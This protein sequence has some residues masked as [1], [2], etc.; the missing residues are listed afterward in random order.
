MIIWGSGSAGGELAETQTQ[1]CT[2]CE[3]ERPFKLFLEYHYA[4]IYFFRWVTDKK[5]H[6]ACDICRRGW[7]LLAKEVEGKIGGN[8]IPFMTRF[9]WTIPLG[10]I[11]A[12]MLLLA[13]LSGSGVPDQV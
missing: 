8:P 2:T 10:T 3:R 1:H 7:E 13:V 11:A 6:E 9:G 12:A 5:Y 4:H